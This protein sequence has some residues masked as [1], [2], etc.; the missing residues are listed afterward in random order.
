MKKDNGTEKLTDMD[1]YLLLQM[2]DGQA[3]G[4]G[5]RPWASLHCFGP[6]HLTGSRLD[7]LVRLGYLVGLNPRYD[8]PGSKPY[9]TG[10]VRV[11]MPDE[12]ITAVEWAELRRA[13][14]DDNIRVLHYWRTESALLVVVKKVNSPLLYFYV[15]LNNG[16][17]VKAVLHR[18]W[19]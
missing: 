4:Y 12:K 3:Y 13:Y 6:R 9:Y 5:Y 18:V 15:V 1:R 19:A 7:R 17:S 10:W 16:A 2:K 11:K 8:Y 14:G